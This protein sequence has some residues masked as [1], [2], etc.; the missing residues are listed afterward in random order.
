MIFFIIS[1]GERIVLLL[2]SQGTCPSV[3]MFLI[4]R[5]GDI[6][7][8]ITGSVHPTVILF[9]I[10]GEEERMILLPISQ[11][12]HQP[13]ILFVISIRGR[14]ILLSMSQEVYTLL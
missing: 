7:L 6:T 11:S 5:R 14:I 2:I 1:G 3:I 9:I 4:H 10:S 12:V 8:N 13:V